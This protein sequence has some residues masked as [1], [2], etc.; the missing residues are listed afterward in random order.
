MALK[1]TTRSTPATSTTTTTTPVTNSHKALIDQGVADVLAVRDADRSQN[2]EDSDDSGTG[3][4]R[5]APHAHCWSRCCLCNDLDKP[6][7]KMTDKYCLRDEIKKLEVELWNLK[8][9]GQNP[10]CFK[11]GAQ[12]HFKRGCPKLKNNNRGNKGGNGNA[13]EKV[14]AVSHAGTNPDSNIVT[15]TFLLKNRYAS[16][17]FDTGAD[18][19]FV[20]IAFSSQIDVAPTTL[21]HYYD[22]ELADMRIIS[23]N[24][25]IQG[26]TLNFL[27]HPFNID[28]ILIELGSFDVIIGKDW[29]AKY[30]VAIVCVEKIVLIL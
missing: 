6:K 13:L 4:R 16:I 20:S 25:I 18:R 17:L 22:V 3:V 9:K 21:D 28:L 11:C 19:S 23:L 15:G 8:V 5:Q 2:C 29:L 26:F 30:H 27:N 7:K 12:G 10:T 24:T 14:Y 1:R